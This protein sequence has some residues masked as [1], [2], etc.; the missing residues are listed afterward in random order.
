MFYTTQSVV[1]V[2]NIL[3]QIRSQWWE[4]SWMLGFDDASLTSHRWTYGQQPSEIIVSHGWPSQ[5]HRTVGD[6]DLKQIFGD[7]SNSYD[8]IAAP[9]SLSN[10]SIEPFIKYNLSK[11]TLNC[12][13]KSILRE[14]CI[15]ELFGLRFESVTKYAFLRL[16]PRNI[17]NH[18]SSKF[19]KPSLRSKEAS[20]WK[21]PIAEA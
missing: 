20:P 1:N 10:N 13:K 19:E 5:K 7:G 2:V 16:S 11:T 9:S 6:F 4:D 14:M 3:F 17:I 21:F 12:H 15:C 8:S 18:W